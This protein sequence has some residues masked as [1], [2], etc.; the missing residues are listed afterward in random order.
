MLV[1]GYTGRVRKA[2]DV[3]RTRILSSGSDVLYVG[4]TVAGMLFCMYL[5][6]GKIK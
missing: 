5:Q 1:G 3:S 2:R 6:S 4:G